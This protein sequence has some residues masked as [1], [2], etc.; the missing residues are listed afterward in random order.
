MTGKFLFI[1]I[2]D[3]YVEGCQLTNPGGR[4]LGFYWNEDKPIT[5]TL[6]EDKSFTKFITKHFLSDINS[7]CCGRI[8]VIYVSP[9]TEEYSNDT[10]Y[11]KDL[12]K[13]EASTPELFETLFDE[14][15][16]Y[17]Y[18]YTFEEQIGSMSPK[19]IYESIM[20]KTQNQISKDTFIQS[21]RG[22]VQRT[23]SFLSINDVDKFIN[24]A[25]EVIFN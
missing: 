25:T 22:Y 18:Y 8:E 2:I 23:Y 19:S 12:Y 1:N 24:Y 4:P 16:N 10:L 21:M 6:K 14:T 11:I 3:G 20:N 13:F 15:L 9:D 5:T 17:L 7:W